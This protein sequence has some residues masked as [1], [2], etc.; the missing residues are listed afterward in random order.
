MIAIFFKIIF[1]FTVSID[2]ITVALY[3]CIMSLLTMLVQSDKAPSHLF[4]VIWD[5]SNVLYPH[6]GGFSRW[7][8]FSAMARATVNWIHAGIVFWA[9]HIIQLAMPNQVLLVTITHD[10]WAHPC[11]VGDTSC[12]VSSL[13]SNTALTFRVRTLC[14]NDQ[15]RQGSNRHQPYPPNRIYIVWFDCELPVFTFP[16]KKHKK[17]KHILSSLAQNP[18]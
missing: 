14:G 3:A 10:T 12:S 1:C 15:A 4:G 13:P 17:N 11:T 18:I 16:V 7:V 9:R 2:C 6:V 8:T 5:K